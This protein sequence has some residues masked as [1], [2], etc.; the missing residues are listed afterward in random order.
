MDKISKILDQVQ[1]PNDLKTEDPP[2]TSGV[3][4]VTLPVNGTDIKVSKIKQYQCV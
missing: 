1:T 2:E 4:Y 3:K